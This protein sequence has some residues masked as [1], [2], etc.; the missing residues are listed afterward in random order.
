MIVDVPLIYMFMLLYGVLYERFHHITISIGN[1]I[2]SLTRVMMQMGLAHFSPPRSNPLISL[3][4]EN[5]LFPLGKENCLGGLC[6]CYQKDLSI[7]IES[8]PQPSRPRTLFGFLFFFFLLSTTSLGWAFL[9]SFLISSKLLVLYQRISDCLS[10][11][12]VLYLLIPRQIAVL[13]SNP[14]LYIRNPI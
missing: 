1:K 11:Y 2:M 8:M 9:L 3:I 10:Y 12:K 4:S 6:F 5:F 13:I 14:S 7:P